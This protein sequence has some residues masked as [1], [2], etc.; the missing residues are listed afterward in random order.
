M[1]AGEGDDCFAADGGL[2][3][4][5]GKARRVASGARSPVG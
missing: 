3:E 5:A 4:L 2:R 1:G